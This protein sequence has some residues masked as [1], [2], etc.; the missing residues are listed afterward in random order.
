MELKIKYIVLLLFFS[1]CSSEIE[2][3]VSPGASSLVESNELPLRDMNGQGRSVIVESNI[4]DM[5]KYIK[6]PEDVV[7]SGEGNPE[8]RIC[9]D[10]KCSNIALDWQNE[11]TTINENQFLQ[12]RLRSSVTSLTKISAQI[13]IG[14]IRKNWNVKTAAG[15][16]IS[17]IISGHLSVNEEKM[18]VIETPIGNLGAGV[19]EIDLL[20]GERVIVSSRVVGTGVNLYEPSS[21]YLNDQENKA[22]I[23]DQEDFETFPSLFEVDILT[24]NRTII[25]NNSNGLGDDFSTPRALCLNVLENKAYVTDSGVDAIFEVDL[26]TGN[27][28]I[29]SDAV[30][31]SGPNLSSPKSITLN[32][33]E[34]TLYVSDS[35]WVSGD[36]VGSIIEVDIVTGNR[37]VVSDAM[38]GSGPSLSSP[39]SITLNTKDNKIYV[40]DSSWAGDGYLGKIVEIDLATGNRTVI[41]SDTVGAGPE[42]EYITSFSLVQEKGKAYVTDSSLGAVLE[43]DLATG[44]RTIISSSKVGM[45]R[46]MS[47]LMSIRLNGSEDKA[48]VLNMSYSTLFEIDLLSG[49]RD[50]VFDA[51]IGLGVAL[52]NAHSIFLN[53]V[54]SKV[55]IA[56]AAEEAIFEVDL[57]TGNRT[58]ISDSTTGI[59][60]DFDYP[61]YIVLNAAEDK[62]YVADS[63][64]SVKAIFEVDLATGN[65]TIISDAMTGSG[66]NLSNP[67]SITLNALESKAYVVDS[68]FQDILFEIDLS[69]GNRTIVSDAMTGSGPN[70][71][72][73]L[74]A[75]LNALED[76]AYVVDRDAQA[77]FM[78]D[79][80]T[81]DRTVISGD[82]VG[83]GTLFIGP[84]SLTLN[85]AEDKIYVLDKHLSAVFEVDIE[86]GDRRIISF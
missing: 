8:Y 62:A 34:N 71:I 53:R 76:K 55:Y 84:Y 59:G 65:R 20:T 68:L 21:I 49:D 30:T 11:H 70:F 26:V 52:N 7:I 72:S 79:L 85:S 9:N 23:I 17:R 82:S 36:F 31:G 28:R 57:A 54:E 39:H 43:M 63:G 1:S 66:P 86:T 60:V 74:S 6:K 10:N 81:G 29:I 41:S 24:G 35:E 33:S 75:N 27:R 12:L 2:I 16:E 77:I 15:P 45:G 25:S 42:F 67:K 51:S 40:S 83:E 69:T 37:T 73:P 3:K 61:C 46:R 56:D 58:I 64:S 5:A 18:F 22:Y 44:N 38:I 48:Y 19:Y 4:L 80:T 50:V 13:T 78:V 47:S 14:E 32:S